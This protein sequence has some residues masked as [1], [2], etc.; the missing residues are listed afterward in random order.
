MQRLMAEG[1]LTAFPELTRLGNICQGMRDDLGLVEQENIEAEQRWESQMWR[2]QQASEDLRTEFQHEF[3]DAEGYSHTTTD[4]IR[5]KYEPSCDESQDHDSELEIFASDDMINYDAASAIGSPSSQFYPH[6]T[7]PVELHDSVTKESILA[8]LMLSGGEQSDTSDT[9]ES[10]VGTENIEGP[11][12]LL[13]ASGP[14]GPSISLPKRNYASLEYYPQLLTDFSSG[15][16]RINKWLQDITLTSRVEGLTVFSGLQIQFE[17]D[18]RT[19]PSNWAQ[20]TM[21]FW[22]LDGAAIPRYLTNKG[23]V[24]KKMDWWKDYATKDGQI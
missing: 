4:S 19:I 13:P 12:E 6:P 8:E 16:D 7:V 22:D 9:L 1:K 24:E 20:L 2:L 21:A 18:K 23:D 5:S 10:D 14:L 3:E 17:A 15:R 11:L